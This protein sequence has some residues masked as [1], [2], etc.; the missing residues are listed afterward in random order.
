M[1]IQHT[2]SRMC[3]NDI[4]GRLWP[5]AVLSHPR[6]RAPKGTSITHIPPLTLYDKLPDSFR[7]YVSSII[8][9][10]VTVILLYHSYRFR[11]RFRMRPSLS[12]FADIRAI[13]GVCMNSPA[14]KYHFQ[15]SNDHLLLLHRYLCELLSVF[16]SNRC[17]SAFD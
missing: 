3:V 17:M 5:T 15:P 6:R 8:T 16:R 10:K 7:I 14:F 1:L 9:D 11:F 12:T 4:S 13:L 2:L